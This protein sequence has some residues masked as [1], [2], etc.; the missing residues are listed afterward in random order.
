[1]CGVQKRLQ[2]WIFQKNVYL[3]VI[4]SFNEKTKM[5]FKVMRLKYLVLPLSLNSLNII[6]YSTY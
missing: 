2:F 1:M 4:P 6:N 5:K 3:L